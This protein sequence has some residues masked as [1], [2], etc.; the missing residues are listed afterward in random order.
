MEVDRVIPSQFVY[1]APPGSVASPELAPQGEY[2]GPAPA[3]GEAPPG[4]AGG[5][6]AATGP[7]EYVYSPSVELGGPPPAAPPLD[8]GGPWA[9]KRLVVGPTST[10]TPQLYGRVPPRT[11]GEAA[12]EWFGGFMAGF[13]Q[14]QQLQQQ[15]QQ[16]QEIMYAEPRFKRVYRGTKNT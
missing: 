6:A 15:Q 9:Q 11:W 7:P 16:Q 12:R 4:A 1:P 13:Q 5:E 14:Q 3:P 2:Y 10:D 8:A